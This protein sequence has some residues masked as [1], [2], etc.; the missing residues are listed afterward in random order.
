MQAPATGGS[1]LAAARRPR[2]IGAATAATAQN[3]R[4]TIQVPMLPASGMEAKYQSLPAAAGLCDRR[5]ATV[6]ILPG[7]Q[8]IRPIWPRGQTRSATRT[9]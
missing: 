1:F 6:G 3:K 2:G 5:R 4:A 8:L 7:V 9:G